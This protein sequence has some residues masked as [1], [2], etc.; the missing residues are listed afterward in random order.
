LCES[1][2]A[3][4]VPG[5]GCVSC[6]MKREQSHATCVSCVMLRETAHAS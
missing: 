3:E 6:V 4:N 2:G 5:Y 1:C